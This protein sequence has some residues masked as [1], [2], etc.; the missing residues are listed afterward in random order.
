MLTREASSKEV[1]EGY[2]EF[3]STEESLLSTNPS[4][5]DFEESLFISK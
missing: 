5:S 1:F 2:S 4:F 3:A